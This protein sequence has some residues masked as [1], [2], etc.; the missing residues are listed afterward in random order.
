MGFLISVLKLNMFKFLEKK[1]AEKPINRKKK[2]PQVSGCENFQELSFD[3]GAT[4]KLEAIGSLSELTD[5]IKK[6]DK[7]LIKK[8]AKHTVVYSGAIKTPLMIIGEAPGAEENETGLPFV[9]AS[10]KLLKEMLKS[11]EIDTEKIYITNCVF[12]QPPMNRKPTAEEIELCRPMV[13]KQIEL[14]QPKLI[15]LL[16]AVALNMMFGEDFYITRC[17]GKELKFQHYKVLAT[18]HPSYVLRMPKQ[19]ALVLSDLQK[20]ASVLEPVDLDFLKPYR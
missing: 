3:Q 9:G 19:K 17:R 13:M 4:N 16:G 12:W 8:H 10:G 11:M 5:Y 14:L 7:C 20:I 18:F 1:W 6:F 15:L 2:P